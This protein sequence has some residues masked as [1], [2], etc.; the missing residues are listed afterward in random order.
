MSG[1]FPDL[2]LNFE[3]KDESRKP[4]RGSQGF[5]GKSFSFRMFEEAKVDR[6]AT[7][8]ESNNNLAEKNAGLQKGPHI[9]EI[10]NHNVVQNL[11]QNPFN[12]FPTDL[13]ANAHSPS[14]KIPLRTISE[15][16]Q[17]AHLSEG[18][19][20]PRKT[21]DKNPEQSREQ[22][23]KV[24]FSFKKKKDEK[25]L[26]QLNPKGPGSEGQEGSGDSK[27]YSINPGE[28]AIMYQKAQNSKSNA[29]TMPNL[30]ESGFSGRNGAQG[31]GVLF[32]D[33][34]QAEEINGEWKANSR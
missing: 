25:D 32:R 10:K 30:N 14:K 21:P 7:S 34:S 8:K 26:N 27:H 28:I 9:T 5:S 19:S 17:D 6:E 29:F 24:E 11:G 31:L 15:S 33:A 22:K 20:S 16:A 23:P 2:Q 3:R 4:T 18:D 12:P 13:K 1:Y